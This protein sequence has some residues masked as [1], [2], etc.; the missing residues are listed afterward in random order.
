MS[1]LSHSSVGMLTG[2]SGNTSDLQSECAY[3]TAHERSLSVLDM[4]FQLLSK[5]EKNLIFFRH[6]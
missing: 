3:A 4:P 5:D 1:F 2:E 6:V